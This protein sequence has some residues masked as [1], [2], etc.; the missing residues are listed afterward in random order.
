[1]LIW[2]KMMHK[3]SYEHNVILS[4]IH[5]KNRWVEITMKHYFNLKMHVLKNPSEVKITKVDKKTKLVKIA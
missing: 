5:S 4:I 1:M 3:F 2:Y